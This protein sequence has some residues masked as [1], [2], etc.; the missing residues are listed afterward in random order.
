[1]SESI[2]IMNQTVVN[3]FS[4]IPNKSACSTETIMVARLNTPMAMTACSIVMQQHNFFGEG[5][6]HGQISFNFILI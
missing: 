5:L 1:M 6:V 4:A 3:T 2:S